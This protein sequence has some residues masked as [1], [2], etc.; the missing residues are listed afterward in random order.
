MQLVGGGA[1][2]ARQDAVVLQKFTANPDTLMR[3]AVGADAHIGP[4]RTDRFY[5]ISWRIRNFPNGP[6]ES[7]A[8]TNKQETA[9][10]FA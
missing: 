8:P 6:T 5:G 1:L 7:S 2:S 3:S 4:R 9:Y 10:E